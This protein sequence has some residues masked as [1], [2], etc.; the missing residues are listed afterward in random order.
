MYLYTYVATV[1]SYVLSYFIVYYKGGKPGLSR[2]AIQ[3]K[4][5]P[6][7]YCTLYGQRQ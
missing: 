5:Y 7:G 2:Y 4:F 1:Y 6:V 3:G